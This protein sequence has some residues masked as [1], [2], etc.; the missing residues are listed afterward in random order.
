MS[1]AHVDN[2]EQLLRTRLR[3]LAA[4]TGVRVNELAT[5]LSTFEAVVWSVHHL[6]KAGVPPTTSPS[7]SRLCP[8]TISLDLPNCYAT[9]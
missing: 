4:E 6:E 2:Q 5:L 3:S 7:L 9:Q 1:G 8:A